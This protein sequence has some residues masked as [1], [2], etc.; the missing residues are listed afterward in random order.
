MTRSAVAVAVTRSAVA[1]AVTRS[2]VA[3]AVTRSAVA[4][5]VVPIVAAAVPVLLDLEAPEGPEATTHALALVVVP[6]VE[7][8]TDRADSLAFAAGAVVADDP[9]AAAGGIGLL[10]GALLGCRGSLGGRRRRRCGSCAER[11][12]GDQRHSGHGQHS[13]CLTH[14]TTF[15]GGHLPLDPQHHNSTSGLRGFA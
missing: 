13:C 5:T 3:V 1:V 9:V 7:A 14:G 11:R 8:L 12:A 6:A 4:V 15:S 10:L 2:A